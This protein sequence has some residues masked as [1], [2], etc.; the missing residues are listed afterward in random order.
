MKRIILAY[1]FILSALMMCAEVRLGF[2]GEKYAQV[3]IYVK[4]LASGR[5]VAQNNAST[6]LVPAS[7]TKSVTAAVALTR[8]GRNHQFVT[9]VYLYGRYADSDK[10]RWIGNLIVESCGDPT[11]DSELFDS[12]PKIITEIIAGLRN[13]GIASI[14]GCIIVS[15]PQTQ[16]GCP[17]Q[18]EIEDVAWAYGAGW[19]GFNYNDNTCKVWPA[20][21]ETR[22][23]VPGLEVTAIE[24]DGPT[25]LL[26]GFD[27]N[28][29]LVYGKDVNKPNWH[30]STTMPHPA[31]VFIY[32]LEQR[33]QSAGIALD[34]DDVDDVSS[35]LLV[36]EHRSPLMG[37]ML[38]EMMYESHNLFAEGMLRSLAPEGTRKEAVKI[39]KD[40]LQ[41]IGIDTRFNTLLDGSGLARAD[42]LRPQFVSDVLEAMAKGENAT[43]YVATFPIAG[44]NGT[45]STLL[46]KTSLE[47]RLA[48]KSGSMN[49]V[50]CFAGYMLNSKGQ[51]THTVVIQV[52]SFFCSRGQLRGCI[53]KFLIDTFAKN[54]GK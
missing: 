25:D 4:D 52:N 36:C 35:R 24:Q 6:A 5:V 29:L 15:E 13:C 42:R 3:G 48:L 16:Q 54:N 10:S 33:L 14:S 51:P 50:Q 30:V 49:G 9:P 41:S 32:A 38:Q 44:K 39:Y 20:T 26:R 37:D 8:F 17:A 43:S 12:A 27:S 28:H 18:W 1:A 23:Y 31:D 21:G 53:E 47:G 2:E 40:V 46:K 22:P 19:F 45:V 11:I 34:G 7:I